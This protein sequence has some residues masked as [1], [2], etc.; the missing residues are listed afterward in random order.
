[1][2]NFRFA[3]TIL[4][5][6]L[7]STAAKAQYTMHKMINVGYVYQNQ[8]FGEVGGK[9][10]FLKNDDVIYRLGGSALMGSA[11]S[12]FA[13]MPKLQADVL[14][15]FE[16]NVDFYHSYYFLIGAEG[17]NK[18][19]APKVGVSLFGLLDLT[20]GYAFSVG[21]AELNGKKLKGMNV[22]FTLNIPTVFIHDMFK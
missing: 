1:M 6:F 22:N 5:L 14:L 10:L 16:K 21:N 11:D 4:S 8:S 20:A 2:M 15:N 7:L 19:V 13:I 12:K 3:I 9:L 18:Y 17:T